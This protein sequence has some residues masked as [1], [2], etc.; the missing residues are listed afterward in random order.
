MNEVI[1]A[2]QNFDVNDVVA[3]ELRCGKIAETVKGKTA[4]CKVPESF[5][6]ERD[7]TIVYMISKEK[8]DALDEFDK[9]LVFTTKEGLYFTTFESL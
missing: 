2:V 6:K 4:F 7:L 1:V 8:Y 3:E 9:D 5:A